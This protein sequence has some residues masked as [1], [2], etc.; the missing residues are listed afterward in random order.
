MSASVSGSFTATLSVSLDASFSAGA[1][2][3]Q[4]ETTFG[5]DA[6]SSVSK[7]TSYTY[8]HKITAGKYGHV[9][10][11]NWGWTMKV[12]K[13]VINNSCAVTSDVTGTVSKMPS[14]NV[15]GYRYWETA[16]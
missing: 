14:A 15:W 13:Y 7:T 9:Q 16:S 3:A 10:Y 6:S 4:A 2:L 8:S 5:I 1:I 11:G 12:R